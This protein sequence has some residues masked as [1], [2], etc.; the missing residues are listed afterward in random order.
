MNKSVSM[1]PDNENCRKS[2]AKFRKLS[3]QSSSPNHSR[4]SSDN[5]DSSRLK[6]I[7]MPRGKDSSSKSKNLK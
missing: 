2:S 3:A 5:K 7:Y 1:S 4:R 6:V